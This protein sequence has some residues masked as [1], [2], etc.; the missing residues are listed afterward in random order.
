MRNYLT[1]A[2]GLVLLGTLV[3]QGQVREGKLDRDARRAAPRRVTDILGSLVSLK[4]GDA[5]GKV[6][7]MVLDDSGRVDYL[8]VRH[9][10]ELLAVPWGAVRLGNGGSI[11]LGADVRPAR[12]RG[13]LFREGRWP[14]FAS[15][16][17]RRSAGEVW[18]ATTLPRVTRAPGE[19]TP[20]SAKSGGPPASANPRT[21]S[22]PL[23]PGGT[24]NTEGRKP[25]RPKD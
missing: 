6:T 15:D 8:I 17:W 19:T 11:R 25:P 22:D 5:L 14:D 7:D 20:A 21:R 9:E 1:A 2:L 16:A 10:G 12:V 4:G 13:L 23:L 3:V 18:G 24:G